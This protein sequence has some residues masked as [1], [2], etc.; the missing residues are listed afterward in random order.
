[1]TVRT[2]YHLILGWY[3]LRST[4][5]GAHPPDGGGSDAVT[6]I[7]SLRQGFSPRFAR[8]DRPSQDQ[9]C[10][11]TPP[12]PCPLEGPRRTPVSSRSPSYH[13]HDC[14]YQWIPESR[15]LIARRL[16]C[17]PA[18]SIGGW[19][20]RPA[21]A[22]APDTLACASGP[23]DQVPT[24]REARHAWRPLLESAPDSVTHDLIGSDS[25]SI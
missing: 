19:V 8:E 16:E 5:R 13:H 20:I 17:S 6:E 3:P 24:I 7:P 22:I 18:R 15:A 21:Y 23:L 2:Q 10:S 4:R 14:I 1:M 12:S 11:V 9:L 25:Q